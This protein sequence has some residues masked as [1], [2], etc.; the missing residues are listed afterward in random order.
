MS[1]YYHYFNRYYFFHRQY[2]ITVIVVRNNSC[3]IN[4]RYYCR[5]YYHFC[6]LHFLVPFFVSLQ[7]L[8]RL[9]SFSLLVVLVFKRLPYCPGRTTGILTPLMLFSIEM[10]FLGVLSHCSPCSLYW[11]KLSE[12]E[13]NTTLAIFVLQHCVVG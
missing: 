9:L 5:S 11:F 10:F 12:Y 6:F 13:E 8:F 3:I 2:I 7:L 4:K 1:I